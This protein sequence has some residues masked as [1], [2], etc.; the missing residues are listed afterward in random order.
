MFTIILLY[1]L[2]FI[3]VGVGIGILVKK[4][5]DISFYPLGMDILS[6]FVLKRLER[7]AGGLT[8]PTHITIRGVPKVLLGIF[9]LVSAGCAIYSATV[10]QSFIYRVGHF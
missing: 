3:L 9:A 7:S 8:S 6:W 2:G 1:F 5:I 4:Q 10:F